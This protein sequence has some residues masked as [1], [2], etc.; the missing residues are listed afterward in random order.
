MRFTTIYVSSVTKQNVNTKPYTNVAEILKPPKRTL[1]FP[2]M[3]I[4]K[5][6]CFHQFNAEE[7]PQI[8]IFFFINLIYILYV[9]HISKYPNIK[10]MSY[11][12][13]HF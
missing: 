8:I 3:I 7:K 9:I 5:K 11:S 2:K 12:G 4:M 13:D 1:V 6:D 10:S